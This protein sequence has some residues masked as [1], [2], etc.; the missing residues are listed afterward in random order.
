MSRI[1]AF[2]AML[3]LATT[4]QAAELKDICG[5]CRFEKFSTCNEF[6]EGINFDKQGHGWAVGLMTGAIVE[7]TPDGKC[8]VRAKTGGK[9]NGA[10]F[11]ADGRLFVTDQQRGVLTYDPRTNAIAVFADKIDGKPMI[12]A[13]DL[14]FDDKGGLYVTVPGTSS[15]LDRTGQFVYFA[16]GSTTAQVLVDKLPYPNGVALAPGGQFVNIGLYGDKTIIN[17]PAVT[18]PSKARGAYAAVRTEGGIGP[19]GMTMDSDGRLYWANFFSGAVGVADTR[20]FV[21]GYMK[22]PDEAGRFTTNLAFH[23]GYIYVTEAQRGEIWRVRVTTKGQALY[24]QP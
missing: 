15:Y 2:L 12:N 21:I 20:G 24:Y 10:R 9:P 18:N 11:H 7:V 3:G 4:A 16:P 6:L 17:I 8:S 14:V 1:A 22:L 19:D 13:N 5:D 23:G